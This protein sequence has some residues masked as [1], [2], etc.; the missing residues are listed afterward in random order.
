MPDSPCCR[1]TGASTQSARMSLS[2][3]A[4]RAVLDTM[5]RTE[6][7]EVLSH[8]RRHTLPAAAQKRGFWHD[9]PA[10]IALALAVIVPTAGWALAEL[11]GIAALDR[12][13]LLIALL[14]LV[15][16]IGV[17]GWRNSH[18]A[19]AVADEFRSQTRHGFGLVG[20][21]AVVA[22]PSSAAVVVVVVLLNL[23]WWRQHRASGQTASRGDLRRRHHRA[24]ESLTAG[25][26][27]RAVEAAGQ[28]LPWGALAKR[29]RSWW[30]SGVLT[31]LNRGLVTLAF[32]RARGTGAAACWAAPMRTSRNSRRCV[33]VAW[34][35]LRPCT[36]RGSAF[37]RSC[38]W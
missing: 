9:S 13:D 26:A 22:L 20:F 23:V 12:R 1:G 36:S 15:L 21:A 19:V 6:W 30:P 27:A 18:R 25:Y 4:S 24:G 2:A 3:L 33:W 16:A 29:L 10:F 37:S 7:S 8:V 31:C 28:R 17:R 5:E 32:V 35:P 34:W 38:R 11:T 14:L